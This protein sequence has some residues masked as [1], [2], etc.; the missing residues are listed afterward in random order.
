MYIPRSREIKALYQWRFGFRLTTGIVGGNARHGQTVDPRGSKGLKHVQYMDQTPTVGQTP[1]LTWAARRVQYIGRGGLSVR[2]PPSV[3]S[4]GSEGGGQLGG[5][6]DGGAGMAVR[7]AWACGRGRRQR[8]RA[9]GHACIGSPVGKGSADRADETYSTS[10]RGQRVASATAL[11]GLT[12]ASE[13]VQYPE[14]TL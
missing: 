1:P 10:V 5:S 12:G 11:E 2:P 14:G 13:D 9:T 4:P 6:G 3:G 8:G 7:V